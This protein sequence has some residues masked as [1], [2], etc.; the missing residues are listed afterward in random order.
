M[1]HSRVLEELALLIINYF[2]T[3]LSLNNITKNLSIKSSHTTKEYINYL[4]RAFLIFTINKF[5]YKIKE[6]L[7]TYKKVYVVDNGIINSLMFDFK[8]NKGRLLENLVAVELKKRSI[9]RGEEVFYWDNYNVECDFVIKKGRKIISAI[10]VC[11]ELNIWN[12]KR[13]FDGL[14]S[15]L[16]EFNLK[17]GLILTQSEENEIEIDGFKIK[18]TPAWKWLLEDGEE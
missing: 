12:K 3:K 2:A 6:Q 15:A 4:E 7:S 17:E 16:K 11:A 1:R 18:I 14:T 9:F 10:Q 13:E 5:S 8:Q